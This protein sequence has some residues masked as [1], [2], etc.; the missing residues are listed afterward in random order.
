LRC[1]KASATL[2]FVS[3]QIKNSLKISYFF[4]I[5]LIAGQMPQ[6]AFS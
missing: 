3:K 4:E 2:V 5:V 6:L 1:K